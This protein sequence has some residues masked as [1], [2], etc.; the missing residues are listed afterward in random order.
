MLLACA[1]ECNL[2]EII[3]Y[4]LQMLTNFYCKFENSK[5]NINVMVKLVLLENNCAY[6]CGS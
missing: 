4:D 5:W 2:N 1:H 6:D 3:L